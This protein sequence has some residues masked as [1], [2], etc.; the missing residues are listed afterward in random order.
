[1]AKETIKLLGESLKRSEESILRLEAEIREARNEAATVRRA[2]LHEKQRAE[3]AIRV[4][5]QH[6]YGDIALMLERAAYKGPAER[7]TNE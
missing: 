2:Y 3:K 6:G 7:M 1:M 4:L 5:K